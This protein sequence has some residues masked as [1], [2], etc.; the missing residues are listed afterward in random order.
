V[1]YLIKKNIKMDQLNK[2]F[3][4]EVKNGKIESVELL[5]KA[6]ADV[7][8][9]NSLYTA[10]KSGHVDI[11]RL[12]LNNKADINTINEIGE[13]ALME[14]SRCGNTDVVKELLNKN[15]DVN[16]QD[17]Y[18]ITSLMEASDRS[19]TQIVKELLNNNADVNLQSNDGKTA[20][21][22]AKTDEIKNLL[23]KKKLHTLIIR[24]GDKILMSYQITNDIT[25]NI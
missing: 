21:D 2:Q 14:A 12:L 20:Y 15:A 1:K 5:L 19:H 17:K 25:I 23:K 10:S 7:N 22:L 18:G 24:Q 8:F 16:I 9:G 4:E 3:L 13:T 6:G 11:V